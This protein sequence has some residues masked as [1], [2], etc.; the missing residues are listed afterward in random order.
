MFDFD[1]D[2]DFEML[3]LLFFFFF[4]F[5]F[6]FFV[7]IEKKS[8]EGGGEGKH[9]HFLLNHEPLPPFSIFF[10]SFAESVLIVFS[11]PCLGDPTPAAESEENTPTPELPG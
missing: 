4:N 10:K 1:V 6:F 8:L 2:V 7:V 11:S 3:M 5:F 9:L